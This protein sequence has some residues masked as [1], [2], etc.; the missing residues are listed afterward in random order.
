MVKND[1]ILISWPSRDIEGTI[2]PIIHDLTDKFKIIVFVVNVSINE[3]LNSQLI[4]LKKDGIIVDFFFFLKKIHGFLF[5]VYL[6]KTM[7]LLK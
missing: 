3:T 5:H 6:K 7:L 1:F 4:K 2:F